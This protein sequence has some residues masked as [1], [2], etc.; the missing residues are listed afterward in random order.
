MLSIYWE[1]YIAQTTFMG[2]LIGAGY[3]TAILFCVFLILRA[4]EI[5]PPDQVFTY[6]ILWFCI[7]L[8]LI[9]LSINRLL[10]I[11][12]ILTDWGRRI[13]LGQ[14]WYYQRYTLQMF[15]IAGVC[16]SIVITLVIM[17]LMFPEMW[18]QNW[19]TLGCLLLLIGL[20]VISSVSFHPVDQ[21]LNQK[22]MNFRLGRLFELTGV[23][24]VSLSMIINLFLFGKN[25]KH[26]EAMP[27]TRYI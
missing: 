14:G 16:I 26:Q 3:A 21:F 2:W 6:R 25:E 24:S 11:Q 18:R 23:I 17:E 4:V 27:A 10:D 12:F 13:A 20:I 19:L 8:I 7:A 1:R 5:V 9:F 22:I 15:F